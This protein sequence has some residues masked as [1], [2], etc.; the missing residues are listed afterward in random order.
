ML[1]IWLI[2]HK[3]LTTANYSGPNQLFRHIYVEDL[4]CLLLFLNGNKHPT[5]RKIKIWCVGEPPIISSSTAV[6][7]FVMVWLFY[8]TVTSS[9]LLQ[10]GRAHHEGTKKFIP[11]DGA[12]LLKKKWR[13]AE[14][15]KFSHDTVRTFLQHRNS[16]KNSSAVFAT[17]GCFFKLFD[18]REGM[19]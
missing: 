3:Q 15:L 11:G 13:A 2:K 4:A 8:K 9:P 7:I 6:S 16:T 5:L 1:R 19:L 12:E 17:Q 14:V 18:V 10:S